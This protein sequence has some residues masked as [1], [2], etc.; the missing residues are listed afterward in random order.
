MH[1]LCLILVPGFCC[2]T[3]DTGLVD[4]LPGFDILHDTVRSNCFRTS[5]MD[6]HTRFT[7]VVLHQRADN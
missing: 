2:Q 4:I 1:T 6:L 3:E 7:K 5:P